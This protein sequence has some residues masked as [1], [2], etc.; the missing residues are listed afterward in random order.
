MFIKKLQ[1]LFW[2]DPV[3][4]ADYQLLWDSVTFDNTY[5]T[6]KYKLVFGI[7]CGVNHHL[8]SIFFRSGSL[9][10]EVKESFLWVFQEFLTCMG[11]VYAT[12][13]TNQDRT[14]EV[15]LPIIFSNTFQKSCKWHITHKF[16]DKIGHIHIA[17]KSQWT[18][19]IISR[20]ML[21]HLRRSIWS[22]TN[23]LFSTI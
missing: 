3:S 6:N 7:F 22:G 23:E 18:S 14:M 4:I 15:Y 17:I 2:T 9:S 20:T 5:N 12:I 13:I 16:T 8:N 1:H 10:N 19:Y 21:S 11:K